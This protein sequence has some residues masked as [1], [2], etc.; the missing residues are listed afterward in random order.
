MDTSRGTKVPG[1]LFMNAQQ[2]SRLHYAILTTPGC[3][4]IKDKHEQIC[5]SDISF[6][7]AEHDHL[8][9]PWSTPEKL[10]FH[11]PL[12]YADR[13][14]TPLLLLH[15]DL[16]M[17]CCMVDALQMLTALKYHGTECRLC[18]FHG[19]NHELSRS[20]MPNNRIARL[21]ELSAWFR[22]WDVSERPKK[23]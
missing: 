11:S 17:H 7:E 20:G 9:T 23:G 6:Q 13:V 5:L 12:K 15:S 2:V 16:D 21:K 18:L 19:E 8:C 4:A 22:R 3:L 10:W 14:K 1:A